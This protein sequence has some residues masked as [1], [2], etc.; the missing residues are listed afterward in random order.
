MDF[1]GFGVDLS[2]SD[3]VM[4]WLRLKPPVECIP[5]PYDMYAKYLGTLTCFDGHMGPPSHWYACGARLFKRARLIDS[6]MDE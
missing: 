3:D 1:G 5:H 6:V 2:P 4:A